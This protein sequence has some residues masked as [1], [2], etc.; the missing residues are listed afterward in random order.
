MSERETETETEIDRER[1]NKV[2][3]AK[4]SAA[5]AAAAAAAAAAAT[6][7]R[8]ADTGQVRPY[9]YLCSCARVYVC[10][11]VRACVRTHAA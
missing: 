6:G 2:D 9:V 10:V 8:G 4:K 5:V 7:L 11:Y 3:I 1:K